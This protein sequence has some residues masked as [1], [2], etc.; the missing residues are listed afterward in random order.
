MVGG[1]REERLEHRG[2]SWKAGP[3]S[4][5]EIKETE[6]SQQIVTITASRGTVRTPPLG[7][8]EQMPEQE[9]R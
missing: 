9:S 5:M 7:T 3:R 2:P 8:G 4:G 6:P 1:G